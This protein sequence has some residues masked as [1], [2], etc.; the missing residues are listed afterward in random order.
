MLAEH[1][2]ELLLVAYNSP[3]VHQFTMLS[4]VQSSCPRGFSWKGILTY[5]TWFITARIWII[6]FLQKRLCSCSWE[7]SLFLSVL[8]LTVTAEIS[9]FCKVCLQHGILG[10]WGI[11]AS[12]C[13]DF[14]ADFSVSFDLTLVKH[15]DLCGLLGVACKVIFAPDSGVWPIW[16]RL[17]DCVQAITGVLLD[18]WL[19]PESAHCISHLSS[20]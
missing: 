9:F 10:T 6:F 20:K 12:F 4:S 1:S 13:P 18:I 3:L 16:I 11:T 15:Y 2:S 7:K 14:L 17:N 8:M 5:S 19:K